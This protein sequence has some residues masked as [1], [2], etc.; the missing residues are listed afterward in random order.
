VLVHP[1]PNSRH[2]EAVRNDV[3]AFDASFFAYLRDEV[4]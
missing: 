4:V 2:A 3:D 1:V